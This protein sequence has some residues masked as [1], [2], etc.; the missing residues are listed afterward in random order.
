M[1]APRSLHVLVVLSTLLGACRS[2][3]GLE[4]SRGPGIGASRGN[5]LVAPNAAPAATQDPLAT[6]ARYEDARSDG[7][8]LLEA[9]LTQGTEPVRERAA[10]ALGRL[11]FPEF[12]AGVTRS[13]ARALGDD[14]P[15]VRAAA[16]FA[17]GQRGDPT[18]KEAPSLRDLDDRDAGVRARML[19]AAGRLLATEASGPN[20]QALS[21]R[22]LE[23]LADPDDR[24]RQEAALA[25]QR[26][27]HD[28]PNATDVDAALVAA[29]ER[30]LGSSPR[31][32]DA[33][34][35]ESALPVAKTEGTNGG[36]APDPSGARVVATRGASSSGAV[37]LDV[38]TAW[39]AVFTLAR[40]KCAEARDV[41]VA[42]L[43]SSD[44][45][46]RTYGA[47]GLAAL[48]YDA[49]SQHV[50]HGAL[51]DVDE[52]V[53]CEVVRALGA[54]P[55]AETAAQ[56]EKALA[57]PSPHVQR[58][59][60]EAWGNVK[61]EERGKESLTVRALRFESTN[62]RNAAFV[63]AAKLEGD[64]VRP[65]VELRATDRDPLARASA[66]QAARHLSQ[67]YA[68]PLLLRLAK[69]D[70]VRVVE[71]A[72]ESLGALEHGDARRKLVELL[73]S[74]DN[75]V[76]LAALEALKE[77]PSAADL[78]PLSRCFESSRGDIADEIAFNVLDHAAKI[79]ASAKTD[80]SVDQTT[81]EQCMRLFARGLAHANPYV[82][83]R[84]GESYKA[85]W[86][87]RPLPLAVPAKS[88]RV[89]NVPLPGVD[90]DANERPRVRIE[91][92]KGA[93]TFELFRD[94]TPVHVH[95]FLRHVHDRFYDGTTWHRV[96]PDF[97]I[98]GGDRRGDGNGGSSWRGDAL[99]AEFTPRKFV[100]GALGMPRN[101]DPESGGSQIFVCHRETP[102]LDG[103]YTLFG[104]LVEGFDVLDRI[105]VGDRIVS[106]RMLGPIADR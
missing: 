98:Q 75:G 41:F 72:C 21:A 79:A 22:V 36:H 6:I 18:A 47:M 105:E 80:D 53:V 104:Q 61:K 23:R 34:R 73:A 56:L 101:D 88:E 93:M 51:G 68:L 29:A 52:R 15:R 86:P 74:D 20:D 106:V 27:K 99:R 81:R 9:L 45:R 83:R 33:A 64:A 57:H 44:V 11:P 3:P 28:A 91:T 16:A 63:S 40:R 69:D 87:D 8:G 1:H 30:G 13:L 96:V 39:R 97:V 4:P 48:P 10:V 25:P 67:E 85:T 2:G 37:A 19:E 49:A 50:L 65:S 100:R 89:S 5:Q 84:A 66:A 103:R 59:A 54:H 32:H 94:E 35:P 76:R 17:L 92:N 78:A 38:E 60:F 31:A 12:G 46:L 90:Y 26:W 55:D 102:H 24:V 42:A 43:G 71:A 77:H 14:S 58:L 95:S 62:V 82:R 70:D 7:D